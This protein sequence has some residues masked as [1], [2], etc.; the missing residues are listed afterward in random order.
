M[1][2]CLYMVDLYAGLRNV[3]LPTDQIN[4]TLD[5][6]YTTMILQKLHIVFADQNLTLPV[7]VTADAQNFRVTH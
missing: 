1:V 2:F 7:I 6:F 5:I 3:F 4:Q